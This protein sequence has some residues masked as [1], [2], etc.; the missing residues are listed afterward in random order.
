MSGPEYIKSTKKVKREGVKA[1]QRGGDLEISWADLARM[2]AGIN[3]YCKKHGIKNNY[4][5]N[6][7]Y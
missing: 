5:F 6:D 3:K 2:T 1:R 4:R 7:Y